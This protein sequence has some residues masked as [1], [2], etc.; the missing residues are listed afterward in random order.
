MTTQQEHPPAE[1]EE[2]EDVLGCIYLH[3]DWRTISRY[4]TTEQK[5]RWADAVEAWSARLNAGSGEEPM[6][7]PRWWRSGAAAVVALRGG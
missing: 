2:L 4:L 3:V 5:E 7:V 6:V 1:R